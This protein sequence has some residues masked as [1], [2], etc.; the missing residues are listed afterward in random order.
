[1][2]LKKASID[3]FPPILSLILGINIGVFLIANI[4][5]EVKTFTYDHFASYYVFS[6]D[7]ELYIL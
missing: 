5:P 2:S 6:D 3:P 7:F 1:M 4:F